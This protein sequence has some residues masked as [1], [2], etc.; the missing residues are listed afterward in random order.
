MRPF[1]KLLWTFVMFTFSLP[2]I[3]KL[4]PPLLYYCKEN[5]MQLTVNLNVLRT[6]GFIVHLSLEY[7]H[8]MLSIAYTVQL[9]WLLASPDHW[10]GPDCPTV[11]L[12][13]HMVSQPSR[14]IAV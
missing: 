11:Q 5:H 1:A 7:G 9:S 2:F 10:K 14:F 12:S 13:K 6:K 3:S 8:M 4:L